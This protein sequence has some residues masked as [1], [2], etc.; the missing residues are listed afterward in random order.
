MRTP[1]YRIETE[2]VVIRCYDPADAPLLK[3]C[4]DSS[5][6]ELQA[7]MPWALDDPQSVAEKVELLRGLRSRFDADTDYAL[8]VFTLD[9]SRQLGGTGLHR[10]GTPDSLEIGYFVR[11]DSIGRGLATHVVGTLTD[12]GLRH[13]GARRIQIDVE[14]DNSASLAIPRKLGYLEEGVLRGRAAWPDQEP[15]DIVT[16]SLLAT[17]YPIVAG[18]RSPAGRPAGLA[19]RAYDAAGRQL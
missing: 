2:R 15:R 19:Y 1:P 14:A 16:F 6:P 12:V 3:E 7:R 11:T 13:C 8:G 9:G 10:R 5:L 4:V 17:E 18:E